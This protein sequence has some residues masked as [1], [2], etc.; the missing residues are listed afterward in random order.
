M[1]RTLLV[2][3]VKNEGPNILEW[4]AYH[5]LIGFTDI[6]VYQNDSTDE[7][8]KTLRTLNR[9]GIIQY[10]RN[11]APNRQWQ[12]RAYRRSALSPEYQE[13]Q[14]CMALDGDEF[15][16]IQAGDGTLS[17]LFDAVGDAF[18]EMAIN[19]RLF[20]DC[21]ETELS[22]DLVISRFFMAENEDLINERWRG[23][24]TLFRTSAFE[25]PGIH[26]AKTPLIEAPR[27]INGSGLQQ[28]QFRELGW[29]ALDPQKRAVAQ[30]N[31][32]A[33][34]DLSSFLLK[35]ARGSA[36]HPD[37]KVQ[38]QY[39]KR[40]SFNDQEDRSIQRWV[41]PV[42][43]EMQRLNQLSNGRLFLLREKSLRLWRR[44]LKEV[45]KAPGI[46]QLRQELLALGTRQAQ[47]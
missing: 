4:V 44:Q 9:L 40:M 20:G 22:P 14:W 27:R 32:Y 47:T 25:R 23:V 12:N 29:R 41:G 24:K 30:V 39:W 36:S 1:S 43:D 35:S 5:R 34:R 46:Q 26:R 6:H 2:T 31:H 21:A 18:D 16:N 19:W 11:A 42:Q 10:F 28:G 38:M 8:Q 37:R 45:L 7:T 13:C 33:V 17:A 3:T 15:L